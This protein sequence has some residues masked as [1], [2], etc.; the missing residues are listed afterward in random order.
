MLF[1]NGVDFDAEQREQLLAL[2]I[3]VV[4]GEVGAAR[5]RDDRL[6]GVRLADGRTV[7]PPRGRATTR[8]GRP[9]RLPRRSRA[10][11]TVPHASGMGEHVVVD[12]TGRTDVPGVWAAGNVTDLSA[13]VGGA[14]AARAPGRAPRSTRT[15]SL[16]DAR[17][18]VEDYRA[19]PVVV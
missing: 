13:Q 19:T 8:N 2:A 14:A 1:T 4:D 6:V 5:G 10:C 11:T 3:G 9:R 12:A 17:R 15:S 16:E 18:A 7:A